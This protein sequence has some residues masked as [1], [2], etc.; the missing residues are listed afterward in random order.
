MAVNAEQA[1]LY[2]IENSAQFETALNGISPSLQAYHLGIVTNFSYS[3]G[4]V[5]YFNDVTGS[6]LS[7]KQLPFLSPWLAHITAYIEGYSLSFRLSATY[8]DSYIARVDGNT[9]QD[10]DET[11][12]EQSLYV[13]ALLA[14]QLSDSWEVRIEATNLTN[15]Q[16]MQYSDSSRRPYNTT[17]SGRNY[18]LGLTYHY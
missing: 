11:G 7:T 5:D 8:R 14:Y 18:Y 3:R 6:P 1:W 9:A 4:K 12:F 13:D 10:E 16:E 17:V 2:G 15:E